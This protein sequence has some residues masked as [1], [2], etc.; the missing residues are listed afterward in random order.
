M[1]S[2]GAI[3]SEKKALREPTTACSLLNQTSGQ[4]ALQLPPGLGGL[5]GRERVVVQPPSWRET[6]PWS[7]KTARGSRHH[8]MGLGPP[9]LTQH[10]QAANPL[11]S[12]FS[13]TCR[14]A[15]PRANQL[16]SR[17]WRRSRWQNRSAHLITL[18]LR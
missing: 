18:V 8:F 14:G 17:S 6:G 1:V 11:C 5:K 2:R 3:H 4:N 16:A 15:S 10:R 9:P 7:P 12:L 13:R